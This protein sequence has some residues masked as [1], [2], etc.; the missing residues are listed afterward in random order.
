M[1]FFNRDYF[2]MIS[3]FST[4]FSQ[5]SLVLK[6]KLPTKPNPQTSNK[7]KTRLA[8]ERGLSPETH[9]VEVWKFYCFLWCSGQAKKIEKETYKK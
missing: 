1:Y 5:M 6:H 2:I 8:A 3:L 7:S 4:L 9:T